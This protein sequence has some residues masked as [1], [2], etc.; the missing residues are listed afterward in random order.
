MKIKVRNRLLMTKG[1]IAARR[2][3]GQADHYSWVWVLPLRSGEFRVAAIEV[4]KDLIDN[5]ECF[6]EDDMTRP[7]VKIV[8]SVDDVDHAVREAGVDPE[9]LDA[10]WYSDFPL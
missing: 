8:D 5:D 7:Y 1:V 4:P 2:E 3:A 9:T 6:F 10:P